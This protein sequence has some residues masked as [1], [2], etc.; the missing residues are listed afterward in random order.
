MKKL[1]L[2]LASLI[3]LAACSRE[4]MTDIATPESIPTIPTA[5]SDTTPQTP[6]TEQ[7]PTPLVLSAVDALTVQ[8]YKF[9][10]VA[11]KNNTDKVLV[12]E[13][14]NNLEFNVGETVCRTKI[15]SKGDPTYPGEQLGVLQIECNS[16][17]VKYISSASCS[18]RYPEVQSHFEISD[19]QDSYVLD[20]VCRVTAAK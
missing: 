15:F 4:G 12:N 20:L 8:G 18:P 16:H 3:T 14:A 9:V 2:L 6:E 5:T 17:G 10:L 13:D 7:P 11:T 19:D 1:I